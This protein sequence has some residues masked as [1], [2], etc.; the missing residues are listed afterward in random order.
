MT[1]A[2][3]MISPKPDIRTLEIDPEKDN[4]MILAC[5]G[6]WNFMSSQ[7]VVDY[8]N[9]RIGKT[10]DDKLSSIC[11]EV[12]DFSIHK[13]LRIVVILTIFQLFE[14]CLA[15]DT[16]G[17]GTG[18]DNMTAVIVKFKPGFKTVQ[19][20]VSDTET[21][22]SSGSSEVS[23]NGVKRAGEEH[24]NS[25]KGDDPCDEPTSKKVKLDSSEA[26]I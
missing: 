2:E 17:D 21:S 18:C 26:K 3:Q 24:I 25:E 6:I 14:H 16:M 19:D 11:E 13:I 23:E 5:D 20:S 1:L 9:Q 15:P 4:W 22:V 10:P 7:E 12:R 8:V